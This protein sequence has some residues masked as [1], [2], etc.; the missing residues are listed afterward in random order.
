MSGDEKR[1]KNMAADD[2][3]SPEHQR[4]LDD[5]LRS[6]K[7][8]IT[9][10]AKAQSSLSDEG[11]GSDEDVPTLTNVV[12]DP[13]DVQRDIFEQIAFD[14]RVLKKSVS[15]DPAPAEPPLRMNDPVDV[16]IEQPEVSEN[17]DQPKAIS[18]DQDFAAAADKFA[19]ENFSNAQ[20]E[21][22]QEKDP[23][24]DLG[25]DSD[26]IGE[27]VDDGIPV[28]DNAIDADEVFPEGAFDGPELDDYPGDTLPGGFLP[29][30]VDNRP[31]EE[32]GIDELPGDDAA[33]LPAAGTA[34]T[35][36]TIWDDR[37]PDSFVRTADDVANDAVGLVK[38]SLN[39]AG[40]KPL[41]PEIAS[42]I[43]KALAGMLEQWHDA[44]SD[45]SASPDSGESQNPDTNS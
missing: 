23:E 16:Q 22:H 33:D 44:D 37:R 24:E 4:E 8:L 43:Q 13:D 25:V 11:D 21:Q 27:P 28:V 41:H 34:G 32:F 19:E 20:P 12:H 9:D 7:D 29:G 15:K 45:G 36:G 40:E 39:A 14:K 38:D 6:L 3:T 5:T 30:S 31:Y 1:D 17:P 10:P 2:S 18:S 42:E 26:S 35:V